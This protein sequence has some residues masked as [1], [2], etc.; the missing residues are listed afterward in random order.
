MD[1]PAGW[2]VEGFIDCLTRRDDTNSE[3]L[4]LEA[5]SHLRGFSRDC[6]G[7]RESNGVLRAEV[8]R[9]TAERARDKQR[10]FDYEIAVNAIQANNERLTAER[11]QLR[12]ALKECAADYISPPCTVMEG[13][14]YLAIEF[15]RRWEIAIAALEQSMRKD[16][17]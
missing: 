13:A 6:D 3:R 1:Q 16:Q 7:L 15:K 11:D 2:E 9:L 8:S 5:I 12:E 17:K 10:L 4:V 14:A